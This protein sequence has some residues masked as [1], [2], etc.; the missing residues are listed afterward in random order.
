MRTIAALLVTVLLAALALADGNLVQNPGF[1]ELSEDQA[2]L[3]AWGLP[4]QPGVA[5]AWDDEV[6]HSGRRSA[7]VE[8]V[9]ADEQSRYVQAWRQNLGPL[10]PGPLWLSVWVKASEVTAGRINVL[11]RDENGEVL[12]NQGIGDFG[13]TFDWQEMVGEID[14]EPK[15]TSLQLVMGLV[16]STG[17]VWFDD[18]SLA[19]LGD[20]GAEFGRLTMAPA[21][22]QVAGASVPATFEVTVGEFGLTRGG[23]LQ[24][25]WENWRPAREFGLRNFQVASDAAGAAFEVTVPPRKR[26]WPPTPK[27]IAC[28]VTLADGG[29]I[30]PA[31]RV[32]ISADLTYTPHTN[33]SCELTAQ[34]APDPASGARPLDGSL[35]VA[36]RGGPAAALRCIAEAR[37]LIGDPARLTLAV[38]DQHGNPAQDFR[39]T[40]RLSCNTETDLPAEYAFTE[41]DAGSHQFAVRFPAEAVS[42]VTATCGDLSAT[43]N[44]ILPRREG[45]PGV[46]FGDIHSH[47]EISADAVGDP[48]L[49][50]EYARRSWGL[51]F[52]ALTD[53]SPRA[54]KWERVVEVANRHNRDGRFVT[55]VGFEWSDPVKGHRNAY[56]RGD[57]GPEQPA[58]IRHNMEAWWDF[59][60]EQGTRVITVPHHPNTESAAK[61]TDGKAVWGPMDWSVINH[62]YQRIVEICQARGSF[63]VPGGPIPELRVVREDRGASVQT[64]LAAGHRLGF[65]GSTDTHSGRPGTGPA[66]CAIVSHDFSRAG[67]WDAMHGRSCY[68]TT[69]KHILVFFTLNDSPMG[70]EITLPEPNTPRELAW[71]VI[72]TGPIDRVDLLRNNELVRAWDGEGQD[73]LSGTFRL[74]E[75]LGGTEWWYLRAIQDDTEMAWSSPIW[76]DGP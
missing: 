32:T 12:R 26:T 21:E 42:R 27:P 73:D 49:A 24:L 47:C 30:A 51:D 10:P 29:P 25:R 70:S 5:F 54:A 23:S 45:E 68:A 2:E 7:R 41:E 1:E 55:F 35:N 52:A 36:A 28:I 15:A 31:S 48:D 16:K 43:S 40:V 75:A 65:I 53:H 62:R 18:V 13:G 58:S 33:V 38:T 59:F 72:G 4:Q 74:A 39:G 60:E 64:A 3:L 63:E 20:I 76:V 14:P 19:P 56:Y 46:Y 66:R 8:G 22:P 61:T 67:L 50:Y 6:S 71:R 34:I 69:G 9:N 44:P 37:P 17:T 57:T 11:H